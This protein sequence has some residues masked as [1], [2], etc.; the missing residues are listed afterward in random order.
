MP[1]VVQH[2]DLRYG[3]QH[4]MTLIT[5]QGGKP[6]LRDG[7]VGTGQECC[8]VCTRCIRGGVWDCRYT[9]KESCEECVRTYE[10]YE[11]VQTECDGSC[12][13]GTSPTGEPP[14]LEIRGQT[15]G[16]HSWSMATASLTVGCGVI[17][18]ATIT[19]GGSGFARVGRVSPTVTAAA[20]FGGSGAELAVTLEQYQDGCGFD[21]WRVASVAVTAAGS[22]Y[23]NGDPVVFAAASGD[24]ESIT[25]SGYLEADGDG[26]VTAV[27][28]T[29]QGKY[30]REDS[31]APAYIENVSVTVIGGGG[32]SGA[33]I[34]VTID[35][36]PESPTF[37]EVTG[38]AVDD[39]GSGY[40]SLC[41]RTRAVDDCDE[42]PPLSSPES[43]ECL[44]A[45]E[46]GPCGEW[47]PGLPCDEPC[48]CPCGDEPVV[49]LRDSG[50]CTQEDID[51]IT[52]F[53]EGLGYINVTRVEEI[54]P[55]FPQ[56]MWSGTCC[57]TLDFVN[58]ARDVVVCGVP[59]DIA[60]C[61]CN[62][63]P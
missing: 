29:T 45:T 16:C 47:T 8:C 18:S 4:A 50:G 5:F 10:C 42:C 25:A 49:I 20:S 31:S 1:G 37:G 39:G 46:N 11:Q 12:P 56:Y 48:P 40:V 24:T 63:F 26:A 52:L 13:E 55:P 15:D 51:N 27:V 38:L 3:D 57:G 44:V 62:A 58:P 61:D 53:L 36:D 6:V 7:K 9:T 41:E 19:S 28:V 33:D 21:Y 43:A 2:L 60:V 54:P 59:Y 35:D 34:A 30:Y 22:G 23:S 17:L 32:G 14:T